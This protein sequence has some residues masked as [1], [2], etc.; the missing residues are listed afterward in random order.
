MV[1]IICDEDCSNAPKKILLREW[2]SA[3]VQGKAEAVLELLTEGVVWEVVGAARFEGKAE[4]G[5]WLKD[6]ASHEKSELCILTIITHGATGSA[7]GTVTFTDGTGY[8][9]CHV[10]TFNSAGKTAKVKAIASYVIGTTPPR[11]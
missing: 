3:F 10:F 5:E 9:F 6:A 4:V 1:K 2:L 8:N 7:N 11:L